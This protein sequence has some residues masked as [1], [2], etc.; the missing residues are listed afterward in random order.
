M[1]EL[2]EEAHVGS[3]SEAAERSSLARP[4]ARCWH[5]EYPKE[6]WPRSSL[7]RTEAHKVSKPWIASKPPRAEHLD[8]E[9][10]LQRAAETVLHLR[11]LVGRGRCALV[12][13]LGLDA[14]A[15]EIRSGRGDDLRHRLSRSARLSMVVDLRNAGAA[16]DRG[17]VGTVLVDHRHGLDGLI[18][19]IVDHEML[20]V[21]GC[22]PASV[23]RQPSSCDSEP[24]LLSTHTGTFGSDSASPSAKLAAKPMPPCM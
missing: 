4:F 18:A 12:F 8:A 15:D 3:G 24:S 21:L 2:Y 9:F 17:V 10:L 13:G 5:F 22:W 19:L 11:P 7:S 1:I 20:E 23:S 14:Q 6:Q 16:R